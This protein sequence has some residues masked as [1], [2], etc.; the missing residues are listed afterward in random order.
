MSELQVNQVLYRYPVAKT[1]LS[2]KNI[3]LKEGLDYLKSFEDESGGQYLADCDDD[4]L[5]WFRRRKINQGN[6]NFNLSYSEYEEGIYYSSDN[7]FT[8]LKYLNKFTETNSPVEMKVE[9]EFKEIKYYMLY[10]NFRIGDKISGYIWNLNFDSGN[11]TTDAIVHHKN[12]KFTTY[13]KDQD[14]WYKNCASEYGGG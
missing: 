9:M 8:G 2:Y 3:I 10:K 11:A 12:R 4:W 13:D 7:F 14:E 1:C 6:G 5:V